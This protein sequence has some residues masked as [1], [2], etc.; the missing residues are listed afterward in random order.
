M[1]D[2]TSH[3]AWCIVQGIGAQP[4]ELVL[5]LDHAGCDDPLREVASAVA[6]AGATPLIELAPSDHLARSPA[7]GRTEYFAAY[8][9]HRR[10]RARRGRR[11]LWRQSPPG[12]PECFFAERGVHVVER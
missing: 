3:L 4:G 6:P 1:A 7:S 10:Q 11:D 2:P 5:L 8:D 9:R 12:R